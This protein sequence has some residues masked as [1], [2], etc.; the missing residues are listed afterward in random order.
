VLQLSDIHKRF[1]RRTVLGG[2]S[3]RLEPGE[4]YGLLGPNG[5]G[6]S[7]TLKIITG[8]VRADRGEVRI[9]GL[10]LKE[11]RMRALE[12]VGAQVDGPAFFGHLSGRRNLHRLALLQDLPF[13]QADSALEAVRLGDRGDDQVQSYSTGMRQRLGIAGTL[14]GK[15]RLLIL[16]EPTA[17][18]DPEGRQSILDLVRELAADGGPTVLFTSHI[19]DEVSRLCDRA[20]ILHDGALVHEGAAGA[21]EELREIYF[22]RTGTTSWAD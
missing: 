15:P 3:L 19:F 10:D 21:A 20:G 22:S 7:T 18:L 17:G 8:L 6:K 4:I 14:L 11:D 9:D 16:D 5:A 1:G 2:L 13:A 12:P